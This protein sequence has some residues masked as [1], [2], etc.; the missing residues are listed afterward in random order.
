MGWYRIRTLVAMVTASLAS[1]SHS[2]EAESENFD[3]Y[4]VT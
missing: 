3:T 1:L 2:S 4:L